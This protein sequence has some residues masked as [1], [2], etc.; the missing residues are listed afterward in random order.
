MLNKS[1]LDEWVSAV[2][3]LGNVPHNLAKAI[4]LFDEEA[5]ALAA[6][7]LLLV[8]RT[9]DLPLAMTLSVRL[10]ASH[11]LLQALVAGQY[12]ECLVPTAMS[13]LTQSNW[14]LDQAEALLLEFM[15]LAPNVQ[16]L[17]A[18]LHLATVQRMQGRYPQALS[19]LRQALSFAN[20]SAE[21]HFEYAQ[22]CVILGKVAESLEH[23]RAAHEA[24]PHDL[25][26]ARRYALCLMQQGQRA[27]AMQVLTKASETIYPENSTRH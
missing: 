21:A 2:T 15:R 10:H 3:E 18:Y 19:S 9:E 11:C 24:N 6:Q 26:I 12:D 23:F 14:V 1:E 20:D 25:L 4:E 22:T 7:Q 5:Y 17:P 27:A 13:A 16:C 8:L